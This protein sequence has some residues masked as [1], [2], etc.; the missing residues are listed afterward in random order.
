MRTSFLASHVA[1]DA[2]PIQSFFTIYRNLFDRLAHDERQHSEAGPHAAYPTFGDAT[3]PWAPAS[4]DARDTATRTFYNFWMNFVT[5][6]DFAWADT[7]NINE[8][9]DRRV[10]RCVFASSACIHPV[11]MCRLMER[12]NK[13][14]R[15]DARKEY[16]DTIRVG[17]PVSYA[18]T[19][20]SDMHAVT[21]DLPP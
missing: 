16:N 20:S 10:R 7:W 9:P 3:W 19:H 2:R 11:L 15:D 4:K 13:K 8:A 21:R 5:A 12:D 14:A 6:K 1:H 17:H 18:Y